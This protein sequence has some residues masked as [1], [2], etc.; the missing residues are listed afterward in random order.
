MKEQQSSLKQILQP[1]FF[2]SLAGLLAFAPISFMLRAL[3]NDVI[4]LEYP[5]NHFISQCLRNG[6]LPYWFNTWGLGFPL[7][8]NLTWGIFSTPQLL[9]SSLF[10]YNI[11]VL[12]AEFMFFVLLAGWSMFHLLHKYILKDKGIAQLLAISYMLSGF[13]VGSTQ[14]LLYITATCFIPLVVSSLLKLLYKPTVGSAFQFAVT[15]SLMFTSVYAAFNIITTYS[16]LLF[17]LIWFWQARNTKKTK[18]ILLGYLSFAGILIILLCLPCLYYT[19]ELLKS[20][21]RGTSIATNSAFFNSN[22]LHPSALSSMLLPFSSVKMSYSNT[23][24]TMLDS[25]AGLF[26]LLLIPVVIWQTIKE[27]NRVALIFLL[28]TIVF[29][30]I[31]FGDMT[32]ARSMLNLLPG[33]S[34]FRNP[35]IFR[36][37]FIMMLILFVAEAVKNKSFSELFSFKNNTQTK[38][39]YHTI[40]II[41]AICLFV[42]I[43]HLGSIN[44]LSPELIKSAKKDIN[45][46]QTLFISSFIQLLILLSLLLSI[47]K[48]WFII[49]KI[50]FTT[51]LI[52]NTLICTPFFSV[53]SYTIPEVSRI[54]HTVPGFPVQN[55]KP[56]EAA[57]TYTDEKNNRWNN[58]NVFSKQISSNDTYRGPLTLMQNYQFSTDSL[59]PMKTVDKNLVFLE[60]ESDNGTIQ[61]LIQKPTHIRVAVQA[62]E[63]TFMTL[64]QN[65]YPGWKAWYNNN[66]VDIIKHNSWGITIPI[67]KGKGIIDFRYERTSVWLTAL[68]LHLITISFLIWKGFNWLRKFFFKSSSPS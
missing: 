21:E 66:S 67:S 44:V 37:Y 36:F 27:R 12:H 61:L 64:Q 13:M 17:L 43:L 25:Y 30:L 11:Y 65:Y 28:A 15:Y 48:K 59:H 39:I 3:K 55:I 9:F 52:I 49:S 8:S 20:I 4:A 60:S 29:L 2:I 63:Q 5:I 40:W 18:L 58:I 35:A 54:L 33:F 23:E 26:V 42:L 56:A 22:Y 62:K 24:G 46:N 38:I 68:L 6:E 57:T 34:Y 7:Q 10:D 41:A 47:K 50:L 53:S 16:L 45:Y 32:P 51:D 19:T 14:W 31:S 1:Y